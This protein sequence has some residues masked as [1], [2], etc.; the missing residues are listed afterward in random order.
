MTE[1]ARWRDWTLVA[2]ATR[3]PAGSSRAERELSVIEE[4]AVLF[5]DRF[6]PVDRAYDPDSHPQLHAQV[7]ACLADLLD[8][9][10]AL[11]HQHRLRR[12]CFEPL[13]LRWREPFVERALRDPQHAKHP[14]AP[15]PECI[16]RACRMGGER[17]GGGALA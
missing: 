16:D 9:A 17:P 8:Q 15:P 14:R 13:L 4:V 5:A 6:D 3:R 1:P 10:G 12:D 7:R 11:E 2:L